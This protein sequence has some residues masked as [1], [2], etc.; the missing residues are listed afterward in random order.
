[1]MAK[2]PATGE[3]APDFELPESTGASRRLSELVAEGPVVLLFYR[4]HW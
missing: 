3:A 4:G 2:L 1:M